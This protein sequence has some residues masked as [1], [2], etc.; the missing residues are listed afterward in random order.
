[1]AAGFTRDASKVCLKSGAI[2][3]EANPFRQ[4]ADEA[5]RGSSAATDEDEKMGPEELAAIWTKA[6]LMS[7]RVFVTNFTRPP[8][9]NGK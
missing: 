7:E 8:R 1:M 3:T 9:E 4:F 2:M 6:A 5:K